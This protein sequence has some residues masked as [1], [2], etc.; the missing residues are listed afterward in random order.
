MTAATRAVEHGF[1][2]GRVGAVM[3]RHAYL[4][5]RT[6]HRWLEILYWPTVDMVLWGFITLYLARR[7]TGVPGVVG[8]FLGALILW[9]ILFR[10]QQSVAVGFLEDVWSRNLLNIWASPIRPSEYVIGAILIGIVRVA[11]GVGMAI[12]LAGA[13]YG[14][15]VFSLGIALAPFVF[16]LAIMGW[17]VGIVT[18]ALILRFG[19]GVEELAWALAFLF[20]P[21]SAVFY[22]VSVLPPA[23]RVVAEAIPASHVFEGMRQVLA[24][25]P[26]PTAELAQAGGLDALYLV[27]SALYF[28]L[29]LRQVRDRGLLSRFG[30]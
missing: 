20:Q 4:H 24:G 23:L 7:P 6:L 19:Q 21:V 18:T 10:A 12:A 17:A 11:I 15:N 30:E 14:F 26:F 28:L 1:S 29:V 27:A 25:G 5:K 9:D 13:F 22:P 16:L 2:W 8:F 3:L